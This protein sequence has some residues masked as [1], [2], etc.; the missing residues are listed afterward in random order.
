MSAVSSLSS[1][2]QTV[3]MSRLGPTWRQDL[4]SAL[5]NCCA[6]TVS[7]GTVLRSLNV[8]SIQQ[9]NGPAGL[10]G[11]TLLLSRHWTG[12]LDTDRE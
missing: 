5:C 6:L 8:W 9:S 10:A 2:I 11:F 3:S 1:F 12:P 7:R 4:D